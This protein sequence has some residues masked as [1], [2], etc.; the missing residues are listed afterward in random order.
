MPW[1]VTIPE[2]ERDDDL[3]AKLATEAPG[4]LRWIVDG[5]RRF[6]SAGLRPPAAVRGA[7]DQYRKEE[8]VIGRFITDVLEFSPHT[9]CYSIDIKNELDDWCAEQGIEAPHD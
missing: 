7:T 9:L 3:A 1:Q 2:D 5:A 6:N 8:D 4:I